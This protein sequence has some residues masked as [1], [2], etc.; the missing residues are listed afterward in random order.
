MTI[1]RCKWCMHDEALQHYH[2]HIWGHAKQTDEALFEALTF[3][4]F[5]SGLKWE[6]IYRKREGFREAFAQFNIEAV[7]QF[8]AEKQETLRNNPAI[9]R[10]RL[11]IAATVYN[12][13]Q[14]LLIQA[15]HGSF[16]H[17]LETLPDSERI[18]ALSKQFKFIG[19]VS[20]ESFL[21]A[22]GYMRPHHEETCFL[23]PYKNAIV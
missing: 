18:Q 23:F 14:I 21:M 7:S 5:Q 13:A 22:C 12:A 17:Y 9:I 11:K 8:T 2:D 3:E 10:H 20:A 4:A 1:Q 16:L 19:P 15:E 6:T